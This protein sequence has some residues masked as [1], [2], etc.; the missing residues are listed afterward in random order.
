MNGHR[1]DRIHCY[2]CVCVEDVGS[3]IV[4]FVI[5][6]DCRHPLFKRAVLL[7]CNRGRFLE[8]KHLILLRAI[9]S[10]VDALFL[11]SQPYSADR[12]R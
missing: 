5:C 10:T 1:I 4:L 12:S 7:F 9:L 6:G 3:A 8:K 11:F 2:S